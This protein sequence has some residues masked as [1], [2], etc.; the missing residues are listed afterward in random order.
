MTLPVPSRRFELPALMTA[1]MVGS[2]LFAG[3]SII[4][5][6][7]SL[8]G[9]GDYFIGSHPVSASEFWKTGA[10]PIFLIVA[11]WLGSVAWGI[12]HERLWARP[13]AAAFWFGMAA[14]SPFADSIDSGAA[15]KEPWDGLVVSFLFGLF[16]LWY[17]YRK[18]SV[19]AYYTALTTTLPTTG[20]AGA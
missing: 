1:G 6:P 15:S 3:L 14:L 19:R 11:A 13:L 5:L 12:R 20:T 10:G 17:F 16:A 18:R 4:L 7:A 2:A 8:F 9:F